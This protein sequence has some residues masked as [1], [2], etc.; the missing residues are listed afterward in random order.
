MITACRGLAVVATAFTFACGTTQPAGYVDSKGAFQIASD[1]SSAL[2]SVRSAHVAVQST[3][4]GSPAKFDGDV[5]D[6]NM[7]AT[8]TFGPGSLK[9]I[10]FGGKLYIYGPDILALSH[11]TDATITAK[12]GDKWIFIPSGV[13]AD[14]KSFQD[15]ADLT[16]IADCIKSGTGFSKKGTATTNGV[17]TVEIDSPGGSQLFVQTSAPHYPVRMVF[18]A[19]DKLCSSAGQSEKRNS[20]PD[21][22][23]RPLRNHNST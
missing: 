18:T 5:E 8:L 23:R 12:V 15:L 1:A 4:Q 16:S 20:R 21:P 7:S 6:Q 10:I 17:T 2:K 14:Q 13:I 9:L 19:G 22:N 3:F 11:I